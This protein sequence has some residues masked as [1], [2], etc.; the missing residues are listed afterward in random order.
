LTGLTQEEYEARLEQYGPNVVASEKRQSLLIRLLDNVKN[1][2]VILLTALGLL[3]YFTA[4]VRG[5]IVIAIIV[6]LGV[7][8]RFFQE[9]RA[10]NAAEKL[11]A[12]VS[13]TA[14]VIRD[15]MR[16]EVA[17]HELVPGDIVATFSRRYGPGRRAHTD[18]Q[19]PFYQPGRFNR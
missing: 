16:R 1:P 2:L 15:G 7:V 18:C 10:D 9:L 4:D 6:L 14:T 5:A 11:K 8:L 13:T 19:R 12:M 3:S 17:L